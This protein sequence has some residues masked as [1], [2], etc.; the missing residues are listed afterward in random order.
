ML[1]FH[2]EYFEPVDLVSSND[3]D[4]MPLLSYL[5]NVSDYADAWTELSGVKFF[6]RCYL[7]KRQLSSAHTKKNRHNFSSYNLINHQADR[8]VISKAMPPQHQG[9]DCILIIEKFNL[10]AMQLKFAA[11]FAHFCQAQKLALMMKNM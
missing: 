10:Y 2:L 8:L 9:N 3:E 6:S 1:S 5:F 7:F 11:H 4:S